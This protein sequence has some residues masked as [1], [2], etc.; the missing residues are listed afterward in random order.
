[1]FLFGIG[2]LLLPNPAIHGLFMKICDMILRDI[3]KISNN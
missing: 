2:L 3:Y 1:M